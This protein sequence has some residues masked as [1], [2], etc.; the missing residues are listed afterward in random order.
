MATPVGTN[1][2]TSLS[3]T[4]VIPE[5]TDTFYGSNVVFFRAN[6]SWRKTV[7]GGTQVEVPW[8]YADFVNGGPFTGYQVFDLSPNDTIKN[9]ALDWSFYYKPVTIDLPTIV[10]ANHPDAIANLVGVQFEQASMSMCDDVGTDL[11]GDGTGSNTPLVGLKASID[12]GGVAAS[13]AGL[14]RSSNTWLNSTDDSSTATLTIPSLQSNFGSAKE[15]GRAPTLI[16]SR[17]DQ[18]N[19]YL[20]LVQANMRH[21]VNAGGHDEQLA[22]AGFTNALF[23]NVPW[24]DDTKTF[25]G[26]NASNSAIVMMNEDYLELL[27]LSGLD[28]YMED[29][30]RPADQAAYTTQIIWGGQVINKNPA[31]NSK[32]TALTA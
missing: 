7:T 30:M 23:N 13:Y 25:D 1:T 5:I 10:K 12:D 17:T 3:R 31:R 28:F 26:P 20:A 6:N 18:Y 32:M 2:L 22:S 24:V 27:V 19:R 14:T 9:G 21:V 4:L 29:F 8:M 15:G 16:S 11:W